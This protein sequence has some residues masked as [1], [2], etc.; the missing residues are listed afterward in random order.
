MNQPPPKNPIVDFRIRPPLASFRDQFIF[1]SH[2]EENLRIDQRKLPVIARDRHESASARQRS[3]QLLL[4][5]MDAAGVTH[6][7]IMGRDA[8]A[9]YGASSNDEIAEFCAASGNRFRGFAGINGSDIKQAISEVRRARSIGLVGAAFDNGFINLFDDD[10]SLFPIYDAV[11]EEGLPLA[12]TLSLLLGP[13]LEYSNPDRV[14]KVAKRYPGTPLIITH[15]AYPWTTLACAVAYENPN[16]YLM[17]DCY[18]NTRAPGSMTYVEAA[19][20]FMPERLL[21]ASAYP[22]QPIGKSL[23]SFQRLPLTPEAQRMALSENASRLLNWDL[24]L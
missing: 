4:A 9:A 7:V 2:T 3:T 21:Y 17:P 11:A 8:G 18:L 22:V 19:N 15:G 5:E 16:I 20:E 6:G 14:R 10:E 24:S 1:K 23:E 13:T 12:L